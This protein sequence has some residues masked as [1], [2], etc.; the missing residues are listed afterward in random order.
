MADV[1]KPLQDLVDELEKQIAFLESILDELPQSTRRSIEKEIRR[2]R[3]KLVAAEK[4]LAKCRQ[5]HPL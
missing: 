1:C 5:Q 2:L 3:G 4:K